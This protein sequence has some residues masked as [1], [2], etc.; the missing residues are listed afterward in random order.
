[1][2]TVL[3][4]IISDIKEWPV[5]YIDASQQSNIEKKIAYHTTINF[6]H[7]SCYIVEHKKHL[8]FN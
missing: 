8:Y 3:L 5:F 7:L 1:V 2:L 4:T 6:Y